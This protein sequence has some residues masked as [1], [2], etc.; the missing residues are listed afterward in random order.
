MSTPRNDVPKNTDT[1]DRS[2]GAQQKSVPKQRTTRPSAR[3]TKPRRGSKV[4]G[5]SRPKQRRQA[6][7]PAPQKISAYR[8]W[9]GTLHPSLQLIGLQLW[10]P[11][12]FIVGFCLC[13]VFAFHA[14]HPHD[15]PIAL[16]GSD[17]GFVAAVQKAL[18]GEYVFHTYDSLV[19]AKR[20]VIAG[21][22]AVAYDPATNEF[23]KASAHQFQVASLVP[24]TLSAVL[25][26]TG[27][28]T[29]K[30]TEL[31]ALP[32]YDEYG[33]V[34]M[35]VMLAWCIGGY[36]VSMFIGIMGGPLRH[37]TRMA[38][39]VIGGLVISLITN[40]LA[41][42]VVGA[43][44]GHWIELVLIAWGWIVAIGLAV[45]GLS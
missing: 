39:I 22:M 26:A 16:V 11:L 18:P 23:F 36:M 28:A 10:M 34:A 38:V 31:A 15:V 45:N 12:F 6:P 44:H 25:T 4:A 41:G 24:A 7:V 21:S 17:P 9:Y 5:S 20:D 19:A 29:P 1:P 40:T 37:R 13:Y 42:P 32:A 33:T 3:G 30:V 2:G 43:I 35:Y 14:P 27:V 8:R